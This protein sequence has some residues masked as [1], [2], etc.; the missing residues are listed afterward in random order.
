MPIKGLTQ[1]VWTS[2]QDDKRVSTQYGSSET[3][4]LV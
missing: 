3:Y 1:S 4:T 2:K